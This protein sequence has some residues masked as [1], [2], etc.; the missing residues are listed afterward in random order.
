M[1]QKPRTYEPNIS[2]ILNDN[3]GGQAVVA[4]MP[5]EKIHEVH[6]RAGLLISV[7]VPSIAPL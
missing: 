7:S 2:F 3:L 5:A 6:S 1:P 4:D